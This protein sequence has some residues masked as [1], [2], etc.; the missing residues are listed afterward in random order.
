MLI[1]GTKR[2]KKVFHTYIGREK[3]NKKTSLCLTSNASNRWDLIVLFPCDKQED[4]VVAI[5]F[6]PQA[7]QK[8]VV[9]VSQKINI[10]IFLNKNLKFSGTQ[11]PYLSN[12]QIRLDD[13]ELLKQVDVILIF[14][15]PLI[16]S[17]WA[18]TEYLYCCSTSNIFIKV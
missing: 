9:E 16:L 15:D 18:S 3:K 10:Y 2:R 6:Y 4:T 14:Y 7:L 17:F 11:F 8:E 12:M 5:K 13:L 1:I